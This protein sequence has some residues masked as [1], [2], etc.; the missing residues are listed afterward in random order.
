MAASFTRALLFASD[1]KNVAVAPLTFWYFVSLFN[2]HWVQNFVT[3]TNGVRVG[4]VLRPAVAAEATYDGQDVPASSYDQYRERRGV[5]LGSAFFFVAYSWMVPFESKTELWWR[6]R[7][8]SASFSGSRLFWRET[9]GFRT[10]T[11][12]W[13]C[14]RHLRCPDRTQETRVVS[15][16]KR[17][18]RLKNRP[19]KNVPGKGSGISSLRACL[20]PVCVCLVHLS[21]SPV[22]L[23]VLDLCLSRPLPCLW[24]LRG[25]SFLV[26][27]FPKTGNNLL[28]IP[29]RRR[30]HTPH[31]DL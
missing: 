6:F 27:A 15:S 14:W 3:G 19:G 24:L 7:K 21:R 2:Q 28:G 10:G 4:C 11:E 25:S 9:D 30:W 13:V 29:A 17:G 20:V 8:H 18:P 12:N 23:A 22:V 26:G 31:V 16:L 1:F 5:V